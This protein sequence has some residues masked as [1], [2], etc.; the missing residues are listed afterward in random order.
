[1]R[2]QPAHG[3]DGVDVDAFDQRGFGRIRLRHEQAFVPQLA[4][5]VRHRQNPV[6][7]AQRAVERKL[8]EKQRAVEV[9][10]NLF[11]QD[12]Q[13]HRN[14]EI[15]RG[16]LLA[17]VCRRQVHSDPAPGIAEAGIDDCGPH[18]FGRLL[19]GRVGQAHQR[20]RGQGA[21]VEV[22]FYFD[23]GAVESDQCATVDFGKHGWVSWQ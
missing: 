16:P 7:M 8:A 17:Q 22:R 12:Q 5:Q 19:H 6:H 23:D 20:Y 1:M 13:G 9:C 3:I 11:G 2:G 14:G 4:R 15:V 18:A 21:G 10:R